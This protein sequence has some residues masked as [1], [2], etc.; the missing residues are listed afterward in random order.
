MLT[1]LAMAL[2]L[3]ET[4]AARETKWIVETTVKGR[5]TSEYSG[6]YPFAYEGWTTLTAAEIDALRKDG[7]VAADL[8]KRLARAFA[9]PSPAKDKNKDGDPRAADP[10][11]IDEVQEAAF[12]VKEGAITGS[13][14]ILRKEGPGTRKLV[15]EVK[16]ELGAEK[17][18]LKLASA[19]ASGTWDWGGGT[20]DLGGKVETVEAASRTPKKKE[21]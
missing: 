7:K 9:E 5:L 19:K 2:A 13:F 8:A 15:G 3:Q 14:T 20:A 12:T 17:L 1:L 10:Q 4:Q 11:T 6:D 18:T 21:Y 16:G